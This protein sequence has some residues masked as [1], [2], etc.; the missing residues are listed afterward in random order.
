MN[1]SPLVSFTRR[2]PILNVPAVYERFVNVWVDA[3][4]LWLGPVLM[5]G[6]VVVGFVPHYGWT[7]LGVV[8]AL[9]LVVPTLLQGRQP[10]IASDASPDSR[11]PGSLS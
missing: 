6:G 10:R 7:S 5:V 3:N 11:T 8:I 9:G 1:Y 2:E 4:M